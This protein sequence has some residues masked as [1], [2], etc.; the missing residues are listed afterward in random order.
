MADHYTKS[1]LTVV[2]SLIRDLKAGWRP[3]PRPA[4]DL[5]AIDL[6]APEQPDDPVYVSDGEENPD[7]AAD[8]SERDS[9]A[10][11]LAAIS[12]PMID[13]YVQD[14]PH[15]L[16]RLISPELPKLHARSLADPTF[17]ACT[18]LRKKGVRI[19]DMQWAG[20]FAGTANAICYHRRRARPEIVEQL[21]GYEVEKIIPETRQT[22][23]SRS[24]SRMNG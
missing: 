20:T 7:V 18:Q 21:D 4:P 11:D 19:V 23:S 13:F 2:G 14:I 12:A 17:P 9:D 5:I 1:K 8:D 15:L 24:R 22:R 6:V 3:G 16:D 10:S